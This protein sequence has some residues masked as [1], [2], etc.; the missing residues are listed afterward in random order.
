MQNVFLDGRRFLAHPGATVCSVEFRVHLQILPRVRHS[1]IGRHGNNNL[2]FARLD[3]LIA[4]VL[5]EKEYTRRRVI[6]ENSFHQQD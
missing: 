3:F 5:K 2:I 1:L 6:R 4:H